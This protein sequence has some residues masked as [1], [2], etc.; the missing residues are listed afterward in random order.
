MTQFSQ[1]INYRKKEEER[2]TV[3]N[4]GRVRDI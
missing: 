1:Q 3:T 2:G 4:K